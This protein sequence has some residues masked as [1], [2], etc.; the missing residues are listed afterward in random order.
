MMRV[1][2]SGAVV[3]AVVC[4]L[5]GG[6]ALLAQPLP[7]TPSVPASPENPESVFVEGLVDLPPLPEWMPEARPVTIGTV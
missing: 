5:F 6:A 3:V 7:E 1:C 2:R 4:L